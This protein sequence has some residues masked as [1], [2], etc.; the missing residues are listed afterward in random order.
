[1]PA[2]HLTWKGVTARLR[3]PAAVTLLCIGPSI[4]AAHNVP[5]LIAVS[6]MHW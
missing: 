1:M 3:L 6:R 2:L 4:T 5:L